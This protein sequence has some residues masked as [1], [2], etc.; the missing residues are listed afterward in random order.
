MTKEEL[1]GPEVCVEVAGSVHNLVD[2]DPAAI[3][4][5]YSNAVRL[6]PRD[7]VGRGA[8]SL[9]FCPRDV[10]GA[11]AG[12][13]RISKGTPAARLCIGAGDLAVLRGFSARAGHVNVCMNYSVPGSP[14]NCV[15]ESPLR[16]LRVA[17]VVFISSAGSA[18][19]RSIFR[20]TNVPVDVEAHRHT[21]GRTDGQTDGLTD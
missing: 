5:A 3:A 10:G 4:L 6:V 18:T 16:W 8:A 20:A 21:D 9:I 19:T 2:D 11:R 15:S 17:R 12:P 7:V 14:R 13:R 1:G